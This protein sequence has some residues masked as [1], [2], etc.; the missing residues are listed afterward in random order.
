M[1]QPGCR[2]PQA[3]APSPA[4]PLSLYRDR[5]DCCLQPVLGLSSRSH[6]NDVAC[7][8]PPAALCSRQREQTQRGR[9]RRRGGGAVAGSLLDCAGQ[10]CLP[11]RS[12]STATSPQMRRSGRRKT[13][14]MRTMTTRGGPAAGRAAA[15]TIAASAPAAEAP[16]PPGCPTRMSCSPGGCQALD[17]WPWML[18]LS[19]S[20]ACAL[21]SLAAGKRHWSTSPADER[22]AAAT[23]VRPAAATP[24]L[25]LTFHPRR[26]AP[27]QRS[28]S[29][30][31]VNEHGQSNWSM[32]AKH[33][34]GR[35]GKQCR[36][37]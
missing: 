1:E 9:E 13:R 18:C 3:H 19:C 25:P 23:A 4:L 10:P 6:L 11:V 35:I 33:F 20:T 16:S 26:P 28:R 29:C 22:P 7:S 27:T 34:G 2:V 36:E 32:V 24:S 37:R 12:C 5:L 15:A 21:P 17:L 31:L 14:R 30:R 8:R